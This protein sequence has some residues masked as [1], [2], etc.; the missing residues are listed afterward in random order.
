MNP[1][2]ESVCDL[3]FLCR[4][5]SIFLAPSGSTP[6]AELCPPVTI[7]ESSEMNAPAT[8][9]RKFRLDPL[10]QGEVARQCFYYWVGYLSAILL[11]LSAWI[12]VVNQPQS[13]ADFWHKLMMLGLPTLVGSALLL[14]LLFIHSARFSNRFSGPMYR[15]RKTLSALSR[16]ET[17]EHLELR[18][19]D[20][21]EDLADDV[22]RISQYIEQLQRDLDEAYSVSDYERFVRPRMSRPASQRPPASQPVAHSR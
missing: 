20:Y 22:E 1:Q 14:P 4:V 13:F 5:E 16:G 8:E 19:D 6:A 10:V 12:G 9:R 11:F 15:I 7:F 17:N 21:W 18:K 2:S 3:H